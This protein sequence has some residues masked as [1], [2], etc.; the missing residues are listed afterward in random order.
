MKT[1]LIVAAAGCIFLNV[2]TASAAPTVTITYQGALS[3]SPKKDARQYEKHNSRK[4]ENRQMR[5]N[6]K[7]RKKTF[8]KAK[9][10][11]RR[12]LDSN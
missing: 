9:K 10:E 7:Q 8:K 1:L 11:N 3:N 6:D 12:A 2:P 4:D 5:D